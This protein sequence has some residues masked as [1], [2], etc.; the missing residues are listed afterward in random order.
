MKHCPIL[1]ENGGPCPHAYLAVCPELGKPGK[2]R[3]VGIAEVIEAVQ[4]EKPKTKKKT[5]AG[6]TTT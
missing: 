2:C 1:S 6:H 4:T 5:D 3:E